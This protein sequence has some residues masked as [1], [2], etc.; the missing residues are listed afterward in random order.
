VRR[1]A[2]LPVSLLQS[3]SPTSSPCSCEKRGLR[4][5]EGAAP[6]LAP[7][8]GIRASSSGPWLAV[9]PRRARWTRRRRAVTPYMRRAWEPRRRC[10]VAAT[11][12]RHGGA[13]LRLRPQRR[14]TTAMVRAGARGGPAWWRR[15]CSGAAWLGG[16]EDMSFVRRVRQLERPRCLRQ[17]AACA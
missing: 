17:G 2:K 12:W 6:G 10:V 4:E 7:T 5:R 9:S 16:V 11:A 8:I 1:P 15:G 14:S 13:V 3:S